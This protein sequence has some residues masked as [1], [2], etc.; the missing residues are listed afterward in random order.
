MKNRNL[1]GTASFYFNDKLVP[2]SCVAVYEGEDYD[3]VEV[4]DRA[5]RHID[6]LSAPG[7]MAENRRRLL[8]AEPRFRKFG[9]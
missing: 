9:G 3:D 1:M 7:T 5:K 2:S 6:L 4:F 8:A